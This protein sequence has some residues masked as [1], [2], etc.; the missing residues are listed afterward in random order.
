MYGENITAEIGH[1]SYMLQKDLLL[2]WLTVIENVILGAQLN[3]TSKQVAINKASPVLEKYGL[4]GFEKNYPRTLS[5][6]MKQRVALLR[7]LMLENNIIL[8]D[9][10]LSALDAQTRYAIQLWLLEIW[11]D[12]MLLVTHDIDEAVFLSDEVY[13]LTNRPTRVAE[14]IEINLPRPR[15][16][17][18]FSTPEF[19]A[20][21]SKLITMLNQPS[22]L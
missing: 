20:Y 1:V 10:P 22:V 15:G 17:Q 13:V 2:P 7:T 5:G 4:G 8:L 14:K 11:E 19:A 9:E 3:G 12:L 18:I 16:E 21:K 6:G